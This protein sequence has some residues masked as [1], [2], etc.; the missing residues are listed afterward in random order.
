MQEIVSR[1][2]SKIQNRKSKIQNEASPPLRELPEEVKPT[3]QVQAP[4]APASPPPRTRTVTRNEFVEYP[5]SDG[6]AEALRE[7]MK[8]VT[9]SYPGAAPY[10][11]HLES[12]AQ[13]ILGAQGHG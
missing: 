2:E 9:K 5:A 4:A 1:V 7:A 12:T 3:Q 13:Q 10:F 11:H 8:V 6:Q